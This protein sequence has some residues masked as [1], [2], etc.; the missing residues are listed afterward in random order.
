MMIK[1]LLAVSGT[2]MGALLYMVYNLENQKEKLLYELH[3]CK[4]QL[5]LQ[6]TIIK[7]ANE[8]MLVYSSMFYDIQN[9]Y[10]QE[11]KKQK[12]SIANVKTCQDGM[13]Y[14]KDMLSNL[15]GL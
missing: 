5:A 14:L 13:V 9:K 3:S 6:N 1:I 8:E 11:L 7:Q 15:K 2:F 4:S 10:E 12:A